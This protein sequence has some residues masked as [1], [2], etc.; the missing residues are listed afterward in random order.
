[1]K[2]TQE[3]SA[4]APLFHRLGYWPLLG[5]GLLLLAGIVGISM[6]LKTLADELVIDNSIDSGQRYAAMLKTFRALYTS[7]VVNRAH[8]QGLRVAHD[9]QKKN[10]AIPLPATLTIMLGENMGLA[11]EPIGVRLYSPYPFP[12]R[13]S[14]HSQWF[15]DFAAAAWEHFAQNPSKPYVQIDRGA[16]GDTVRYAVADI[17]LAQ[18]VAC[19]NSHPNSPKRDWQV[20]DVRGVLEIQQPISVGFKQTEHMFKQVFLMLL[21]LSLLAGGAIAWFIVQLRRDYLKETALNHRLIE[22]K[23]QLEQEIRVRQRTEKSLQVAKE[24]ADAANEAKSIFLANMSHEIRTP[25]NAILGHA[26]LLERDDSLQQVQ[27][28]SLS[29]IRHSGGHLLNLINDVLDISKIEAGVM[30]LKIADFNLGDLLSDMV[31]MFD[32]RAKEKNLLF[33]FTTDVPVL[34]IWVAG[35]KGKLTQILINLLGN[36]LKFTDEGRISLS[37]ELPEP[38]LYRFTVSDTGPGIAADMQQQVLQP[39]I[40]AEAGLQKGGSGLGLSIVKKHLEL[41]SSRLELTS[42]PGQGTSVCFCLSL[43]VTAPQ[44][45]H[46]DEQHTVITLASDYQVTALVVDDGEEN[47]R[48]LTRLLQDIGVQ[49]TGM[50]DG[51]QALEWLSKQLPDII[52]TD[53]KMPGIDGYQLLHEVRRR[54]PDSVIHVVAVTASSLESSPQYFIDLGFSDFISKPYYFEQIFECLKKLLH[55][56]YIYR[57]TQVQKTCSA[58]SVDFTQLTLSQTWVLPLRQFAELGQVNEFEALLN[59][60]RTELAD[61]EKLYQGL[62]WLVQHYDM[63]AIINLLDE[64]PHAQDQ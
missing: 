4:I 57:Q 23:I 53:I 21:G 36:A 51:S 35:D 50:T 13:K 52:F 27:R 32:I 49:V 41:M 3:A 48:V 59:R 22:H 11:N 24:T 19:H 42:I 31:D 63:E 43:P 64:I 10:N 37:V 33:E 1:M 12:W 18:C 45:Q 6:H 14:R 62:I 44:H 38:E 61:G 29:V 54:Y 28:E 55:I 16:D 7:E 40:Q 46:W 15:D 60:L 39:F 58:T 30:N 20:G 26:Q 47:L 5:L 17:M 9:Y 25:M 56:E 2:E 34:D 8:E